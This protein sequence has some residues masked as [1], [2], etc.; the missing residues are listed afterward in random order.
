MIGR[1]PT[2]K[3]GQI[4]RV[5]GGKRVPLGDALVVEQTPHPYIRAR[6]IGEG[7]IRF[8]DPVYLTEATFKK[9]SR[10][11]VETDDVCVTISASVVCRCGDFCGDCTQTRPRCLFWITWSSTS[12]H[13]LL[14]GIIPED[15]RAR[16][17][18]YVPGIAPAWI[19]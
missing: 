12:W 10:Y 18:R 11:I 13:I 3:L 19:G 4:A 5:R 15:S 1:Y 16:S 8:D 6:D 14:K 9:I 2:I 7:V 17:R